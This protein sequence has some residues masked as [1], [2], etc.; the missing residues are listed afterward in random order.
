MVPYKN[1]GNYKQLQYQKLPCKFY[2]LLEPSSLSRRKGDLV[3]PIVIT[4]ALFPDSNDAC[5]TI[6]LWR[7]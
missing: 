1:T 5:P 3:G 4:E 2:E 6:Q 7:R